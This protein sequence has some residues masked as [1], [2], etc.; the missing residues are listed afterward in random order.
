MSV[1]KPEG[2]KHVRRLHV[3]GRATLYGQ[4]SAG[5]GKPSVAGSCDDGT[6]SGGS[7]KGG[8]VLSR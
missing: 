8:N 5:S 3:A 6:Q 2:K 7:I 4:A 1:E